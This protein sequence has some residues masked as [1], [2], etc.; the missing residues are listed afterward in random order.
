M[1]EQQEFLFIARAPEP[2]STAASA[3][4]PDLPPDALIEEIR[5]AWRIPFLRQKVRVALRN[6]IVPEMNGLLEVTSPLPD[7][8]FNPAKPLHL[9]IDSVTFTHKQIT[10]CA[11]L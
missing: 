2:A 7:Y 3:D 4:A 11:L 1:P 10:S 5:R 8:P 9:R 6:S